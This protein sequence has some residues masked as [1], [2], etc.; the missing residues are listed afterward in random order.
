[1]INL[2]ILEFKILSTM[3]RSNMKITDVSVPLP[4]F[5]ILFLQGETMDNEDV[6]INCWQ[7]C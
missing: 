2:A 6:Q 3:N 4:G 5:E 7:Y 1:M